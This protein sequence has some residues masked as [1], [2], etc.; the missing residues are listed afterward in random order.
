MLSGWVLTQ[1][2]S[3][4]V[5]LFIFIYLF[6]YACRYLSTQ[7]SVKFGPAIGQ[8]G[9]CTIYVDNFKVESTFCVYSFLQ[10]LSYVAG[11]Y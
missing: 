11:T 1:V 3:D 4:T 8:E 9:V 2:D 5:F 10:H 6:M 7:P